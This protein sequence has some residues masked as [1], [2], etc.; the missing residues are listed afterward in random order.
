MS[1]PNKRNLCIVLRQVEG[2]N[3]CVVR[4]QL[5]GGKLT[6]VSRVATARPYKAACA[7]AI[8]A[9]EAE[10]L[11]LAIEANGKPLRRFDPVHDKREPKP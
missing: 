4:R 1:A 6:F 11:H 2:A 5:S 8:G 3:W 10:G 9:A 7:L